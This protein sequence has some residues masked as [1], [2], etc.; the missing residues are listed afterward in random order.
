MTSTS[1]QAVFNN[2]GHA[3]Q[4]SRNI[5]TEGDVTA[6]W[7]HSEN[8]GFKLT[9]GSFLPG[10]Y[11]ADSYNNGGGFAATGKNAVLNP[12]TLVAFDTSIKF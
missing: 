7:K 4:Y 11:F 1:D 10:A 8:V 3:T 5:G 9:L 2:G 6:E 12:V